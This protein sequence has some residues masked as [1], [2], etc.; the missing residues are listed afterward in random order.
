[1]VSKSAYTYLSFLCLVGLLGSIIGTSTPTPESI[2]DMS[3]YQ[4]NLPEC[5]TSY[6]KVVKKTTEKAIL[7]PMIRDEEGFLAEFIAYHQV[8]GF[9][10]IMIFD[11]GSIDGYR[12]EIAPWVNS[13]FVSVKGNWTVESLDVHPNFLRNEF[14]KRMTTKQLLERQCKMQAVE[15]G[16]KY[17]VSIDIDEYIVV[18]D[19]PEHKGYPMSAVDAIDTYFQQSQGRGTLFLE[20]HNFASIPHIQE[21][22]NLLQIEAY[23]TRM[24][25]LRQMSYY[26]TVM[27]K[28]AIM[29]QGG[30]NYDNYTS[31]Y[32]YTCCHFHGC[33]GHDP[34]RNNTICNKQEKIQRVII[35]KGKYPAHALGLNHYSRSVE[36]YTVKAQTWRTSTGEV[37]QGQDS[38]AAA[39]DYDINKFF[40]RNLGWKV[41]RT[42]LKYACQVRETIAK[43]TK[44]VPFMRHGT[45]WYRNAEFGRLVSIPDKRGRYGRP[46]PD[47]FHYKDGNPHQYHGSNDPKTSL[48]KD[49][50]WKDYVEKL[51]PS[52]KRR[53]LRGSESSESV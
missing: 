32:L 10:H 20:K 53:L 17:F 44:T 15:W 47:G 36:K 43:M 1:M 4:Q 16:Y 2:Q 21:P 30:I 11:D 7:C 26:T 37:K 52:K 45:I 33:H 28:I 14:K 24:K 19:I 46:N 9:D 3:P 51:T 35:N 34:M 27:P 48:G 6:D 31:E 50:L 12:D 39:A 23:Q 41:D 18:R 25:K 49:N 29:L 5:S 13:G 22:V 8:H 42:A 40:Q 38:V